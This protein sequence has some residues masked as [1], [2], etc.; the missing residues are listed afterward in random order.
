MIKQ[1]PRVLSAIIQGPECETKDGG[2]IL[3][4]PRVSLEKLPREGV[5][6]C[7]SRLISD[8]RSGLEQR[9]RVRARGLRA[10]DR[11]ARCGLRH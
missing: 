3:A 10:P 7:A 8:Q 6:G 2:L 11:W 5:R 9:A 1:K 4:K